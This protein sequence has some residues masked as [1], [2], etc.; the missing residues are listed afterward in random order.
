MSLPHELVHTNDQYYFMQRIL[1]F[2]FNIF[3]KIIFAPRMFMIPRRS[4]FVGPIRKLNMRIQ[5][6]RFKAACAHATLISMT[7]SKSENEVIEL[8]KSSFSEKLYLF[9]KS[10]L[11]FRMN[12]QLRS[13]S[14]STNKRFWSNRSNMH[15]TNT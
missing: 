11:L 6:L 3:I 1:H 8:R 13:R 12:F 2:D 10:K 4:D 15:N 5:Q 7:Q 14:H 9:C